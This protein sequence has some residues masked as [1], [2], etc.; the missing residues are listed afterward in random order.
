MVLEVSVRAGRT[1]L[2]YGVL[3][4]VGAASIAD[5]VYCVATECG[6]LLLSSRRHELESNRA[7]Y[8]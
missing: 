7:N 6:D 8:T 2:V 1:I 3:G 5:V 4:A